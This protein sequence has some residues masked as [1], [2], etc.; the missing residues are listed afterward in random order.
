MH[1][2]NKRVMFH[3]A[4]ELNLC[5]QSCLNLS[6]SNMYRSIHRIPLFR[7]RQKQRPLSTLATAG[8]IVTG[9]PAG[10][11]LYKVQQCSF[12]AV[13]FVW[14]IGN[15]FIAVSDARVVSKQ[16][17]LLGIYTTWLQT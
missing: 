9:V 1:K 13:S 6:V 8:L 2:K 16:A 17:Y 10:L 14:L 11:Y 5:S 12:N 15:S 7:W 4:F 3:L